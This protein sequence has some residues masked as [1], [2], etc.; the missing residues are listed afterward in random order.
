MLHWRFHPG[1]YGNAALLPLRDAARIWGW[2]HRRQGWKW[3]TL[4]A[5]S[6]SFG[7]RSI[8]SPTWVICA[9][10][11]DSASWNYFLETWTGAAAFARLQRAD[12]TSAGVLE[13][14]LWSVCCRSES[15]APL[16]PP[17]LRPPHRRPKGVS[18]RRWRATLPV[19]LEM[20]SKQYACACVCAW[21]KYPT[22][23]KGFTH[24]QW[25]PNGFTFGLYMW[26]HQQCGGVI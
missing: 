7:S 14:R 17:Q 18:S 2:W 12:P 21:S 11:F 15:A 16:A 22:I 4:S 9:A 26:K 25:N 8:C 5:A 1:P 13:A 10:T 20:S 6:V 3:Q 24:P 19:S 23:S